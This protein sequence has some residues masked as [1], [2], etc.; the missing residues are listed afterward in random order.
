[1]I[2]NRKQFQKINFE[3]IDPIVALEAFP[4]HLNMLKTGEMKG[5][6]PFEESEI[7]NIISSE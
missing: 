3:M 5:V 6:V 2:Y 1:M 7:N 4:S